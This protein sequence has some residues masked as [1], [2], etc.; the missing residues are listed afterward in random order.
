MNYTKNFMCSLALAALSTIM[1]NAGNI[2][3]GAARNAASSFI[4]QHAAPGMFMAASPADLMLAHSEPS[5]AVTGANDYYV[6]NIKGGGFVIIAGEDRATQVLGYSDK[7]RFSFT[8]MP[9]PLQDL[10]AGYKQEIEFLQTYEGND[11]VPAPASFNATT[12]V[13][14]LIKTTWGQEEPYDWQCPMQDGELCVVGCVAT[15]M[16]QVMNYWQYPTSCSS[17]SGYGGGWWGGMSVPGLPAT[18]FDYSLMLDSYCHWDYEQSALIQDTY[19]DAQAQEVA[20]LGRYCGQAVEMDYSPEGS[21]ATTYAQAYAMQDFGFNNVRRTS[22]GYNSSN[23]DNTLKAELDAGRPILYSANDPN[24]GGHAFICDGYDTNGKFHFNFGWYGTCD[25]WYTSSALNMIHRDGDELHFNS[26]HEIVYGFTPPAYCVITAESLNS[27]N[28][29][30]VL[31]NA[32]DAEALNVNLRTSYNNVNVLFGLTDE[33][34]NSVC[35]GDAITIN[36]N[37]FTAGSTINGSITLPET[38]ENGSYNINLYY[39]TSDASDLHTVMTATGKLQVVGR[40]AKYGEP[41]NIGDVTTAISYV[42]DG[43]YPNLNISD[44]TSLISYVL[45]N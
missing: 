41:L 7:G 42:L 18:T 43:N 30:L 15:A 40:L 6:F 36:K 3:A 39:Y 10:L 19:T 8:Q 28:G 44:V 20:K 25:G 5:S 35:N 11:L 12:G 22:K 34:G 37:T 13:E 1:I 23:W 24:A 14:P 32:M 45:K 9:A 27:G 29:L 38:L 16:A 31:G 17:I 26:S 2:D 4:R 33:S 21:G